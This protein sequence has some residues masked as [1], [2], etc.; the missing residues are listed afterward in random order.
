MELVGAS[1]RSACGMTFQFTFAIGVVLVAFWGWLIPDRFYLQ[2][3]Y[4]SHSFLL[5]GHWW[6][7]DE[8]PRWLWAHGKRDEAIKIVQ[9]AL[10]YV[11]FDNSM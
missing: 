1:K 10:R 11:S 7:V 3:I 4:G 8:S 2:I 5:I 6:L 9:N